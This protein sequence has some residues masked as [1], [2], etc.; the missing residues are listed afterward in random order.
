MDEVQLTQVIR[1][2]IQSAVQAMTGDTIRVSTQTA[3]W[4]EE[5]GPTACKETLVRLT[6]EAIGPSPWARNLKNHIDTDFTAAHDARLVVDSRA[7]FDTAIHIYLP[8]VTLPEDPGD[9]LTGNSIHMENAPLETGRGRILV[10][11]DEAFILELANE[12]LTTL[13]YEVALVSDGEEA[14]AAYKTAR[15]ADK[16]FDIVILDLT[17][18]KGMGGLEAI[19]HLVAYDPDVKAVVSSGYSNDPV[20]SDYHSYGF[21][22]AVQKPYRVQDMDQAL[23][24]VLQK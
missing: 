10:M 8:L 17:V 21:K 2:I 24:R 16:R 11:D 6:F 22:L 19:R 23:S 18:H 13:G 7:G 12:M 1:N 3:R 9:D 15:E 4:P 5:N 20:M 14:V